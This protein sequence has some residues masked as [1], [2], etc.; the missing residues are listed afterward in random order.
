MQRHPAFVQLSREH[1]RA[2]VLAKRAGAASGPDAEALVDSLRRIFVEELD[3]HFRIEETGLLPALAAVGEAAAVT[4]T[5]A[6]HTELRRRAD[7]LNPDDL[8]E[9]GRLLGEHV[10]FEERQLFPLAEARLEPAILAA[11]TAA[12]VPAMHPPAF[13]AEA[14]T[15][16]VRDPLAKFLGASAD[17]ILDYAY[18]DA[19]KLAGHS[20][21]TVAAAFALTR[22]ALLTLYPDALPERGAIRAE[23]RS[24]REQGVTGVIAKVV[25][26]LTGADDDSGF[27]GLGGHFDRRS[28][29]IF[30]A[31]IPLELR[32]TRL[33]NGSAV[34]AAS[35]LGGIPADPLISTLLPRCLNGEAS[36]EDA[37]T[38]SQAWQ[39]RVRR[40]LV[41]HANDP[42]VFV[43]Q[44]ASARDSQEIQSRSKTSSG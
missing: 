19:V 20:C 24:G 5:L 43:V 39:E 28:K 37:A 21:P 33:D 8:A 35:Q 6:E 27:K 32:L 13:F 4:R 40:I 18:L 3:P 31:A 22:R 14:P 17:G 2:L 38:F 29:L 11:L 34:D 26:L 1:H 7:T 36:R 12:P 9:F 16:R 30:A 44:P 23:F 15:L 10:R 25:T 41:E 42:A